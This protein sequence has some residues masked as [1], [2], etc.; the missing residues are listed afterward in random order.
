MI[1]TA[2]PS[3][4]YSYYDSS[5]QH[6]SGVVTVNCP[7]P[8][9]AVA[10]TFYFPDV[11]TY[12]NFAAGAI[13][14]INTNGSYSVSGQTYAM[15]NASCDEASGC[16]GTNSGVFDSAVTDLAEHEA[17]HGLTLG[18]VTEANSPSSPCGD[19]MSQWQATTANPTGAV[20]NGGG[21]QTG[22]TLCDVNEVGMSTTYLSKGGAGGGSP[23]CTSYNE[24]VTEYEG[25]CTFNYETFYSECGGKELPGYP[26][27][28][29]E[30]ETCGE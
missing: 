2:W 4:S 29:Y 3:A 7:A 19:V 14:L 18:D 25:H 30:G 6:H 12:S 20:N 9:S 8:C 21:C 13:T 15:W 1:T 27:T 28:V 10:E 17:G 26:Q 23:P 24:P 5:G 11:N 22:I 16:T